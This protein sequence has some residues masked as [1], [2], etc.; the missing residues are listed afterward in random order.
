MNF[1]LDYWPHE[2]NLE[3]VGKKNSCLMWWS[4][5]QNLMSPCLG[6]LPK[7]TKRPAGSRDLRGSATR[8]DLACAGR[9]MT[10]PWVTMTWLDPAPLSEHFRSLSKRNN[11]SFPSDNQQDSALCLPCWTDGDL[12]RLLPCTDYSG[13]LWIVLYSL[14]AS[15]NWAP[16][17]CK[18][19]IKKQSWSWRPEA[20]RSSGHE[21]TLARPPTD[22]SAVAEAACKHA[23]LSLWLRGSPLQPH[24][25]VS[26]S[27]G[28][29]IVSGSHPLKLWCNWSGE[30]PG[31][32]SFKISPNDLNM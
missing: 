18:L 30:Q 8:C 19:S 3:L 13:V 15:V 28:K 1:V 29:N 27:G 23:R 24:A 22:V 31:I 32:R 20:V 9:Q 26:W 11:S 12:T 17:G 16:A 10:T 25:G 2:Q 6:K 21:S 7:V 14:S 4:K 5:C